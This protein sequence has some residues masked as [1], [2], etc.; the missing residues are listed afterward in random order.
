M[1]RAYHDAHDV[2]VDVDIGDEESAQS[3]LA[4]HNRDAYTKLG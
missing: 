1:L 3:L 4:S 2:D